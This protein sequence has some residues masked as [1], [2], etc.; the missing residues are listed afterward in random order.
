M[1]TGSAVNPSWEAAGDR[2]FGLF[3]RLGTA[4]LG[5]SCEQQ[6]ELTKAFP[7]VETLSAGPQST[8]L[9]TTDTA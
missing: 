8:P 9:V 1:V 3:L 7:G 6:G 5:N 2:L 4:C